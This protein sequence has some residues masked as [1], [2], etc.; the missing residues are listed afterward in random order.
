MNND[1]SNGILIVA[2]VV[3]IATLTG[4]DWSMQ[5]S[6]CDADRHRQGWDRA[7]EV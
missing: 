6:P 4:N 7:S 5:A 3:A 1:A 2:V